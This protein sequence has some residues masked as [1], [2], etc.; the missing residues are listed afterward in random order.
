MYDLGRWYWSPN[1]LSFLARAAFPSHVVRLLCVLCLLLLAAC[2]RTDTRLAPRAADE[3][4]MERTVDPGSSSDRTTTTP[5][6]SCSHGLP[7]EGMLAVPT[8]PENGE[9][10]RY[11]RDAVNAYAEHIDSPPHQFSV[12]VASSPWRFYSGD[13]RILSIEAL[14]TRLRT[15]L[16]PEVREVVL[17]ASWSGVAP[18]AHVRSL[19]GQVSDALDGFPVRGMDGFMW[20]EPDGRVRTTQQAFSG[21]HTGG[22]YRVAPDQPVLTSLAFGEMMFYNERLREANE[23]G[24]LLHAAVG[25]DVHG[26]C[27]ERALAEFEL[28]APHHPI[29][30]YN[31]ALM[32]LESGKAE[33]RATA[34]RLLEVAENAGDEAARELR[35]SLLSP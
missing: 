13:G 19:A 4:T 24:L 12:L 5:A 31:A 32:R 26:L 20:L 15:S 17:Y 23:Y 14:T 29:A 27:P 10:C 34:L 3:Q 25:W 1:P 18:E 30:A 33:D 6:G 8:C 2:A 11:G 22:G 35:R 28:I 21:W 7:L 9:G 16:K